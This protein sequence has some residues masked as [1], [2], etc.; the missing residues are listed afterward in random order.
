MSLAQALLSPRSI[1]L[2]GASADASRL[3]ARAQQYLRRHG[4]SGTLYPVNPRAAAVLGERAWP[5]LKA[6][7]ERPD[8]AYILVGTDRVAD[9]VADCA[10]AGVKVATILADG[11]AEAGADGM[12]RQARL[13][14]LAQGRLRLLGP[15]SMGVVDLVARTAL[16]VN[17]A[18]EADAPLPA[19]RL[20]VVSHSGSVLGTLLSRGVAR[21]IGF[22]KMVSTGNEAD[23]SAGEIAGLLV[24]DPDTDAI[25]L[26]LETIRDAPAL[27]QA[28][29][30][31]HG[32]GKPIIAYKLGRSAIG[33]ELATSHTGALA[34]SDAA[35]DAFFRAHGIVR[36]TM[37]EALIEIAPMLVGRAP[38]EAPRRAVSVLTSTGG[39][40]A[41]VV[42]ALGVLGIAASAPTPAMQAA[43]AAQDVTIGAARLTDMTLAGT[44]PDKIK[45]VLGAFQDA[46]HTDVSIA[47]V[48]SSAQF[49]PQD[50]VAG[51]IAAPRA[52]KPLAVFL[53]PQADA[54]LRLLSDAGIAAFRTPEACADAVRAYLDW[55]APRTPPAK[56]AAPPAPGAVADEAGARKL[57]AALGLPSDYAVVEEDTLRP[58][59]PCPIPFP[60]AAKIL[61]PD[62]P[63]KTEAGGIALNL[64]AATYADGL[65]ALLRRVRANRPDARLRGVLVAPMA[66]PLGEAII[67]FRRD[68]QV[69]PVVLLGSGGILA[70]LHADVVL[71]VAPVSEAEARAMVDAVKGFAPLRGYRGLRRGDLAALARAIALFSHLADVPGIVEAEINPLGVMPDGEGVVVMDALAV[72]D[73]EHG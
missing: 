50:A 9:A 60:V 40:G 45:A 5:S 8:H 38:P 72:R 11:F 39:G 43:L 27:A 14:G 37:L 53:A 20:S 36:V 42:D 25:L 31:A 48:G 12:A 55:Q 56:L 64:T 67:G 58:G 32:A 68:P 22:A 35:A 52:K 70:E 23:L 17:A 16:T 24:D 30:R 2:I 34:G 51:I 69:G 57:F 29:R 59:A 44:R 65:A 13:L 3:T 71:R 49:R 15:N 73:G 26:F 6:L 1:A 46:A 62:I 54:S 66:R 47:V 21:G 63:H 7:P 61:S 33:A 41:M 28:A 18:F 19:G 10:A 4:F